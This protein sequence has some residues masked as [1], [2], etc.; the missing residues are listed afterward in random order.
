MKMIYIIIIF[1]CMVI[2]SI[3]LVNS[4][5]L[6]TTKEY[7]PLTKTYTIKDELNKNIA[8]IK[9]NTPEEVFVIRGK[10]R[11]VA[12]FTI[13]NF[14]DFADAFNSMEFIDL[15]TTRSFSRP[16]TYKYKVPMLRYENY[17]EIFCDWIDVEVKGNRTQMPVNCRN[18]TRVISFDVSKWVAFNPHTIFPKGNVTIGIFIDVEPE[19]RI[20]WIP[21]LFN[22]R[23]DNWAVWT[24]AL[25]TQL[26][27]YYD[28]NQGIGALIERVNGTVGLTNYSNTAT[29]VGIINN[30]SYYNG[31]GQYDRNSTGFNLPFRAFSL[32]FKPANNITS[33]T[34]SQT[35]INLRGDD[36]YGI[37]TGD[38]TGSCSNEVLTFMTS[39]A[40]TCWIGTTIVA[41]TWNHIVA[42]YNGTNIYELYLNGVKLPYTPVGTMQA[43]TITETTVARDRSTAAA[44]F[45]GTVDEIGIWNRTLSQAE[46][47]QLYNSGA[48]ITYSKNPDATNPN[49]TIYSPTNT[50]YTTSKVN[51]NLT[52]TDNGVIDKCW[53][54]ITNGITNITMANDTLTNF[55]HANNS[56][57]QGSYKMFAYCNDTW[58]NLNDT[59]TKSFTV[60]LPPP[61]DILRSITPNV[62]IEVPYVRLG[63]N[64][65][66]REVPYIKLGRH[67][68]FP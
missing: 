49:V 21:T 58:S 62:S 17:T 44:Y 5:V 50:T 1:M 37:R 3:T 31:N 38:A 6:A 32:W 14:N 35:I 2:V 7:N 48:G 61:V 59:E 13:E 23:L 56:M 25:N 4:Q 52:V 24:E 12:E 55:Y 46:I 64:E 39:T 15:N 65:T 11:Q 63:H 36:P 67:L 45:N 60:L 68:Y 22:E 41:N 19:E 40:R 8:K 30:G 53:Y 18:T 29:N 26:F 20:E 51:F 66:L 57:A 34:T 43:F 42:N 27:G 47:T 54:S 9:L 28:Y 10:D 16:F 33:A